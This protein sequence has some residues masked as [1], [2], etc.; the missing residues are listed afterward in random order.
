MR[1][2]GFHFHLVAVQAQE[3]I[4]GKEG[5]PLISIVKNKT[6]LGGKQFSQFFIFIHGSF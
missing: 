2:S 6:I 3:H 4:R 5:H 1:F